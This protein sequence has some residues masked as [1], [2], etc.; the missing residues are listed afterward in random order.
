MLG[1]IVA[2][3]THIVTAQQSTT[4]TPQV[5]AV[6]HQSEAPELTGSDLQTVSIGTVLELQGYRLSAADESKAKIY[7]IQK[8]KSI[9]A[10]ALGGWSTTNDEQHGPQSQGVVVPEGLLNGPSQVVIEVNGL[11]STPLTITIVDYKL[12]RP[13][14]VTPKAGPPGTNVY[15]ECPGFH[16]NDEIMITDAAGDTRQVQRN[17]STST[18]FV[19]PKDV[20]EGMLTIRIASAGPGN[21]QLSNPVEFLV[22][23]DL[24]PL[25]LRAGATT[26]VAPGQWLDLQSSSVKQLTQAELLEV[27]YKQGGRSIVVAAPNPNR[28]HVPVPSVLSPG[29]VELQSRLWR[30]GRASVW[31]DPVKLR[32]TEK[33]APPFIDAIRLLQGNWTQLWP[34]PDRAKTFSAM[35]GDVVVLHGRFPVADATKLKVSLIGSGQALEL[36]ATELDEKANWFGDV[37]VTLPDGLQNGSW[38]MV[39]ASVDDGASVEV[40]IVILIK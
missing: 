40:P 35:A 14:G 33:L 4:T 17:E 10:K 12:P 29:E 27:S 28:P 22:S 2:S 26:P 11:R 1:W 15:V 8:R 24:L 6:A 31:S 9:A 13:E 36:N 38:R 39:V 30:E 32:L 20:V 18:G 19:V 5:T 25:E 21:T 16:I 7:F 37:C 34:G 23:N 3:Q